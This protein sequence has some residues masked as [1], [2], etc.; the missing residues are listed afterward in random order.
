[1]L[2]IERKA[3]FDSQVK[4]NTLVTPAA[5][6]KTGGLRLASVTSA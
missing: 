5:D 2:S 6:E 3:S 1:M 4:S